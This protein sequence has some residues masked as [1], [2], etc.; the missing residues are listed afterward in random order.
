MAG[1]NYTGTVGVF[2][3]GDQGVSTTLVLNEVSGPPTDIFTVAIRRMVVPGNVSYDAVSTLETVVENAQRVG[4]TVS[5]GMLDSPTSTPCA[6]T[7][8][9]RHTIVDVT[10]EVTG[11]HGLAA[12]RTEQVQVQERVDFN[13][14]VVVN[15]APLAIA[16][17]GEALSSRNG[18]RSPVGVAQTTPH[19]TVPR[20]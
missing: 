1:V 13:V 11:S 7:A 12:S 16:A 8:P 9:H 10:W 14:D 5:D 2:G 4:W 17:I 15:S 18:F 19:N 20:V 6:W 3:S